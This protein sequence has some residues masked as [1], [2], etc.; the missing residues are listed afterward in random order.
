[1][2]SDFGTSRSF[3]M[4]NFMLP[5]TSFNWTTGCYYCVEWS[6]FGPPCMERMTEATMTPY[7]TCTLSHLSPW[8]RWPTMVVSRAT[9]PL[10]ETTKV[11]ES[12]CC[13]RTCLTP[14]N[15]LVHETLSTAANNGRG[16][17]YPAAY[18]ALQGEPRTG[19]HPSFKKSR[20][21]LS[22]NGR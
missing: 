9:S 16:S 19:E 15:A 5:P 1:M 14:L 12:T 17:G 3:G 11:P 7:T 21:S 8:A 2:T 22:L 10:I 4:R 20:P 6:W 13:F 18:K